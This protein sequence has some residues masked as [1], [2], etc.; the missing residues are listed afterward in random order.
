MRVS[1]AKPLMLAFLFFGLLTSAA[2]AATTISINAGGGISGGSGATYVSS[3]D[4]DITMSAQTVMNQATS[5]MEVATISVGG[6]DMRYPEGC[7]GN[8]L[9]LTYL[10]NGIPTF[11]SFNIPNTGVSSGTFILS[12]P[13]NTCNQSNSTLTSFSAATLSSI[14]IAPNFSNNYQSASAYSGTS[15]VSS[16]LVVN[17]NASTYSG[18]GNWS[19]AGSA[20]G[21]ATPYLNP[22]YTSF[23][24]G[25]CFTFTGTPSG[26]QRFKIANS[27]YYD[28][29][30]G[31]WFKTVNAGI[32][33]SPYHFWDTSFLIDGDYSSYTSD[34]GLGITGGRI[35]W[36]IGNG[37]NSIYGDGDI[38]RVS[39]NTYSDGIWH[40]VTATRN[41]TTGALNIYVDGT[42]DTDPSSIQGTSGSG[43]LNQ[44]NDLGIGGEKSGGR[45]YY[46]DK[47]IAAVHMY[48][49]VLTST[50]ILQN[51]NALKSN[52]G[53][54]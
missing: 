51:Y 19:N 21:V 12:S 6:L 11:A 39:A 5:K 35:V 7:G 50:E 36:G 54:S 28:M 44:S 40:Y 48:D 41:T 37:N 30:I 25:S 17:L 23:G 24:V 49:R 45:N 32:G 13:S 15:I 1:F 34:F 3:C 53:R 22:A 29:T 46:G 27:A 42:L 26:S 8:V 18:S 47:S 31:V 4:S 43:A 2:I 38:E 14:S 9:D 33:S 52:F 20:G 10:L 16:N